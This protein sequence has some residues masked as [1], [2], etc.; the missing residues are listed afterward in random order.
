MIIIII[1]QFWKERLSCYGIANINEM[2]SEN[3]VE[4]E[5][6]LTQLGKKEKYSKPP[7]L[8]LTEFQDSKF[9][10][11]DL[12]FISAITSPNKWGLEFKDSMFNFT[13]NFLFFF[14]FFFFWQVMHVINLIYFTVHFSIRYYIPFTW[15]FQ[16][17]SNTLEQ[18]TLQRKRYGQP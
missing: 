13:Q 8:N 14:P 7:S 17:L 3:Q 6:K 16:D 5:L 15:S 2:G 11:F 18:H 4:P 1:F 9:I 10:D 12:S